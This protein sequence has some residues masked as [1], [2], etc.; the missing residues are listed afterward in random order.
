MLSL[1]SGNLTRREIIRVGGLS[2]LGLGLP[3]LLRGT[4][5][6]ASL[7]RDQSFGRAKNVLFLWLQGGPPQHETFDPKPDAPAE[8]RGEFKPIP[9]NVPGIDFCE[10]LPRTARIADKLAVIRSISTANDLHD[11]S[12]Y[13]VL[14][15][16]KYLGTQSRQISPT[17]WPYM[18]SIIKMLKPSDKLPGLSSVWLPDLMRLN[19]NVT[20]AG[21]TGGFLGKQW[22]PDRVVFDAWADS[23]RIEGL[24]LPDDIPP[25]RLDRRR[26]LLSQVDAHFRS[27]DSSGGPSLYDL[28]ARNAYELLSSGKARAAFDIENEPESVKKLYGN[29]PWARCLILGRRLIEAG[30]RLV[31]VNWPR[32]G[33]D[34]AVSNP[35]WDTH[36]QN[37]DR[38]QNVLCPIFDVGFT[39]LIEDM[40]RRGLLDETLVVAIGEFGRTPKINRHGGRDHW[41]HVFSCVLAG[42]GIESAQVYGSSDRSGA[43]PATNKVEP[44]DLV[45]TIF[46]LLGID[47]NGFFR[48]ATDRPIRVTDGEPLWKLIGT[49]TAESARRQAGG[50]LAFV[51]EFSSELIVDGDFPEKTVVTPS[52]P[53]R[54]IQGWQAQPFVQK[55]DRTNEIVVVQNDQGQAVFKKS[56]N[57]NSMKSG[58]ALLAQELRN[59]RAGQFTVEVALQMASPEQKT[60]EKTSVSLVFY[61]YLD[62]QKKDLGNIRE[63]QRLPLIF[64]NGRAKARLGQRLRSQDDGASEIERG[65]GVMILVESPAMSE[66]SEF[67]ILVESVHVRFDPRPRDENVTV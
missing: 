39:G 22:D 35:M 19:D 50:E 42:A 7:T 25:L 46:H 49:G 60:P 54:R 5:T 27:I 6:A 17:D 15:G 45:A 21:Q 38:L 31:H 12:G 32:E 30:A 66:S 67:E 20:P 36:A 10:L 57:R 41:G 58:R 29:G 37:S 40:S 64:E 34:T 18:G 2:S 28:Q 3:S 63:F 24:S 62:G 65:V 56:S 9:T 51:P 16:K 1:Q 53:G 33:G 55:P 44:Q 59:P 4:A 52:S 23:I 14:T 13:W 43:F 11:A 61:G 47:T 48:D 26:D 8:I